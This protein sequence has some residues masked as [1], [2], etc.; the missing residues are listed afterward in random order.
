LS[1]S[2]NDI[3]IGRAI[4]P[5]KIALRQTVIVEVKI[6]FDFTSKLNF[7]D[8]LPQKIRFSAVA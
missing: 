2:A 1:I 8:P 4:R 5:S 6:K 3:L 7:F